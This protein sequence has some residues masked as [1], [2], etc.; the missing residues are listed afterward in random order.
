[1]RLPTTLLQQTF[2]SP[3]GPIILVASE[4]ALVGA[5]FD[6]QAHLPPQLSG[7][8]V[9]HCAPEQPVLCHASRQL[10]DYFDG[11]RKV[12]ELPL[13]LGFGTAFAQLV[14][15]A[16]LQ[17]PFGQTCC[18]ADVAKAIGKPSAVRAVGAAVG[19]NPLSVIVPC[20]RVLGADGSLTGYA[21]GLE[22]KTR[23]LQ[24]EGGQNP[25]ETW[26]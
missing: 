13:D 25:Q 23:L 8:S 1:M 20:H 7:H 6:D 16:L 14:W 17:I 9:W 10:K 15:Q 5:W 3:L 18:Y 22:R 2:N 21:G 26:L 11:H 12:F 19:R 4:Q 24:F